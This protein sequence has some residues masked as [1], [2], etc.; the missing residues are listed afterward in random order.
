MERGEERRQGQ[1]HDPVGGSRQQGQA[2][3]KRHTRK[4][5][6]SRSSWSGLEERSYQPALPP[7]DPMLHYREMCLPLDARGR[8]VHRPASTLP[9]A[10]LS[11]SP[12]DASLHPL[13]TS[14]LQVP[15]MDASTFSSTG[16]VAASTPR[17]SAPEGE[18]RVYSTVERGAALST[19]QRTPRRHSRDPRDT[20]P[21]LP[22]LPT[23]PPDLL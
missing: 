1:W 6:T 4:H 19:F 21:P 23:L 10:A 12:A 5:M 8:M 16:A 18:G 22:T 15:G 11:P 7:T 13:F 20:L 2:Y 14:S 9:I 17:S 3:L